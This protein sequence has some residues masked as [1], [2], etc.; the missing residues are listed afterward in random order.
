MFGVIIAINFDLR[1]KLVGNFLENLLIGKVMYKEREILINMPLM[2]LLWTLTLLINSK[3]I[4][5]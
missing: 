1:V 5:S 2:L 3:L 4:K